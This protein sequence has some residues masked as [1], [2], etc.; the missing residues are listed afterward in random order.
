MVAIRLA[1]E[2][3]QVQWPSVI[4][5]VCQAADFWLSR[6]MIVYEQKSRCMSVPSRSRE[7]CE[8]GACSIL[9]GRLDQL[10]L[11]RVEEYKREL[12]F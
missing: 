11:P 4:A 5:P 7:A 9:G 3:G 8:Q 2:G 6:G 12:P 10:I 1:G